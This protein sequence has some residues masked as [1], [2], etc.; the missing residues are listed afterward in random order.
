MCEKW[1]HIT[2]DGT[3]LE[4]YRYYQTTN[5]TPDIKWYC[6]YCT[7]KVNHK[8]FPFTLSDTSELVNINK[9][10]N[11][12]FLKNLP[13]LEIVHETSSYHKYSLPDVDELDVPT[14]LTS[15]YHSVDDFQKLK[16][17][18]NFN[19]FHSNVNGLENKLDTLEN[20]LHEAQSGMDVIAISE[21]SENKSHSFISNVNID[22][23]S[24]F[25]TPSNSKNG[26]TALFVKNNYN[27]MERT[28]LKVQHDDFETVWI[29]IKNPREKNIVCGCVY[30]HAR[31]KIEPF[32]EYLLY[33]L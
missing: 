28:D 1:C 32:F 6:L 3:S 14:L 19:I 8:I 20:F 18:K 27:V 26:G 15:K 25:S 5:D 13:S 12:E 2:C 7:I 22:G 31:Q 11:M 10:N 21:T 23:F 9:S 30:R 33:F 24:P 4:D 16:I 29:E 17:Q